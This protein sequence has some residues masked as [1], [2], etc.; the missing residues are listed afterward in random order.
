MNTQAFAFNDIDK[1]SRCKLAEF[2]TPLQ[3]FNKLDKI[4]NGIKLWIK[5]DDLI[6]FGFGGNKVR[7][8]E[9]IVGDALKRRSNTLVTGAGVQ[10]NHVRATAAV[11]AYLN[12]K[13]IAVYWGKPP[14]EIKGNYYL[15]RM[16][17]AEIRF[18]H[19]TDRRSVDSMIEV[20]EKEL[21]QGGALPYAIPRGGACALGVIAH[22]F[23]AQELY[24]QCD[25]KGIRPDLVTL[26]V[27][28]GGTIAGWIL[29]KIIYKHPWR[30]E[31]F[32]VSRSSLELNEIIHCLIE[33][34]ATLLN[35]SVTIKS[36]HMQIHEGY[37][38][39]GY[40]IP[41]AKGNNT[42]KEVA[43]KQGV[44]LDPVY[45]G[46]AFAGVLDFMESGR[47]ED[48]NTA[49]FLHTGGEPALFA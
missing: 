40:G 2:P 44:F 32:T 49:V 33:Q 4:T 34:A 1:I 31:G 6:G 20:V 3:Q 27:G 43:A 37:I 21:E 5:R 16:L 41:S 15:T 36:E 23:A 42:I 46:K 39:D 24:E 47:Y 30:I 9:Y 17:G 45:T 26:A 35:E 28:S 19:D 11:A 18:T 13:C 12:L 10:S 48:V 8:L 7:A 25:K 22:M 29:A 38:G 14:E